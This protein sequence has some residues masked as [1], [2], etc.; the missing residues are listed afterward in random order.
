MSTYEE[1]LPR[2]LLALSSPLLFSPSFKR[3]GE[4]KIVPCAAVVSA[5]CSSPYGDLLR[6]T[7]FSI[8]VSETRNFSFTEKIVVD[9]K[10]QL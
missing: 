10:V 4:Y 9:F 6:E 3:S 1:Q 2:F 5:I 7:A 8:Q